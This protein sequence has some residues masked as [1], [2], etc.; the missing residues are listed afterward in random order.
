MHTWIKNT[1]FISLLSTAFAHLWAQ[2]PDKTIRGFQQQLDTM[3]HHYEL[4]EL[5]GQLLQKDAV[6]Y[7]Q[8]DID[9]MG[10]LLILEITPR[11]LFAP[12]Y[13]QTRLTA[14]GLEPIPV[15]PIN[16]YQGK[17]LGDPDSIVAVQIVDGQISGLIRQH[18]ETFFIR[19][20]N[21]F[22][23][24]Q[25]ANIHVMYRNSDIFPSAQGI[26]GLEKADQMLDA[27]GGP[28]GLRAKSTALSQGYLFQIA[29]QADYAFVNYH[30][31]N[32]VLNKLTNFSNQLDA[33]WQKDLNIRLSITYQTYISNP[34]ADYDGVYGHG[35]EMDGPFSDFL[36]DVPCN[37]VNGQ[38]VSGVWEQ[39]RQMWNTTFSGVTRDLAIL[40]SRKDL[41]LCPSSS[42]P[43]GAELFGTA[44][45]FATVCQFP[46]Q[47]YV[48]ME[49]YPLNTAGLMAH[50][51]GHS[52]N[53]EHQHG[54]NCS[55]N[56]ATF[57][58]G[59]VQSGSSEY[60][61]TS[62][63]VIATHVGA[64]NNCLTPIF[65]EINVRSNGI[66]YADGSTFTFPSTVEGTPVERNFR[67][68]ND[69]QAELR[70]DNPSSLIS[71][72]GFVQVTAPQ[73]SLLQGESSLFR[74]RMT[75]ASAGSP[76]G[77]ITIQN[78]D[79]NED[80]YNITLKGT[81]HPPCET[82]PPTASMTF[83]SNG[84]WLNTGQV[85]LTA[86]ASDNVHVVA[87]AFEVNGQV[88]G[89][90]ADLTPPY[91][92]NWTATAGTHSIRARALD[93]CNNIGYSPYITVTVSDVP[94]T[95]PNFVARINGVVV[96][97][98]TFYDNT[99]TMNFTWNHASDGSGIERYQ[100][101]LQPFGGPW[102]Y[103]PHVWS[104][105]TSYNLNATLSYGTTYSYHIRAK[106]NLGNW[107]PFNYAG[108]FTIQQ[109]TPT[110]VPNFVGKIGGNTINN[111]LVSTTSP[112]VDSTWSHASD[113]S[114]IERYQIIIQPTTGGW[115][116]QPHILHSATSHSLQTSG[117]IPGKSYSTHIR[118]KN[119]AGVWGPFANGGT[120]RVSLRATK[121]VN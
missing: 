41:R 62:K 43:N 120:F 69:G 88:P 70:I 26:C 9:L 47:A 91:A 111:L 108:Q 105:S 97:N 7:G 3:L 45:Q 81:V 114:G 33:I 19:P 106:N 79:T 49:E 113:P 112:K 50:E 61:G 4:V 116:Y 44:G 30:G 103:S 98:Q 53:A 5:D 24:H 6:H 95:V 85:T 117:L 92:Y 119:N 58:C 101:V 42:F 56:N 15:G 46:Q 55:T 74:V 78:N 80:P 87:V 37:L 65:P 93:S 18:H 67:I 90:N 75:A 107:G 48:V 66:S 94:S 99:P 28:D 27:F 34:N 72:N 10:N 60:S 52:L 32:N 54:I 121:A 31:A 11:N 68:F 115:L 89:G 59:T 22:N 102:L 73:A 13:Q 57:M 16:T 110:S 12:D 17:V 14:D 71:G 82:V 1:V 63:T 35:P 29:S 84:Q 100:I 51:I 64:H 23:P 2:S 38:P 36:N 96:N 40:F 77:A 8:I 25:P 20:A 83:P 109:P 104:T 76:T 118:A 39:F 21:E 86:T